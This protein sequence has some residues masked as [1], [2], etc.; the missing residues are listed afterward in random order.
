MS[1]SNQETLIASTLQLSEKDKEIE[2]LKQTLKGSYWYNINSNLYCYS[3]FLLKAHKLVL[4]DQSLEETQT[5]SSPE[6]STS[7]ISEDIGM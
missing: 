6:T 4:S 5:M 2:E 1:E 7:T 3:A